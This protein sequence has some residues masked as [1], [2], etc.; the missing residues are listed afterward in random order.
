MLQAHFSLFS[1]ISL[2]KWKRKVICVSVQQQHF[3]VFSVRLLSYQPFKTVN[4]TTSA[5]ATEVT[6]ERRRRAFQDCNV[7]TSPKSIVCV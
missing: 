4:L 1:S 7:C 2:E 5:S 6:P 3:L